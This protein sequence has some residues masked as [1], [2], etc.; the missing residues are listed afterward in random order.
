MLVV[1]STQNRRKGL[2]RGG[3]RRVGDWKK[4]GMLGMCFGV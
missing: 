4:L 3:L 2:W 1:I